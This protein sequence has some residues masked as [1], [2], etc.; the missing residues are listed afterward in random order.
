[1]F[2]AA[3][4]LLTN[5]PGW[6]ACARSIRL[7]SINQARLFATRNA[8]L[9]TP[10]TERDLYNGYLSKAFP[11]RTAARGIVLLS[12]LLTI[13]FGLAQAVPKET[14]R[15]VTKT[16]LVAIFSE[17]ET[18]WLQA[19]QQKDETTLSRL[20]SEDFQ[21]WTPQPPGAPIPREDWQKQALAHQLASFRLRQMAVRSLSNQ[22]SVAS[23][24]LSDI[25]EQGGKPQSRDHFVVDIWKK[26]GENWQCTDRYV[27]P[28][29]GN[30]RRVRAG[31]D[32][33]PSGKE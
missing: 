21:V 17:L 20:V 30:A 1:M 15:I 10:T 19:V 7:A 8:S 14:A 4:L 5:L 18:Q 3:F 16:R 24:V 11:M 6:R 13:Q 25:I 23:F 2:R 9:I 31:V 28:I 12:S 27:W 29:S 33:K 32:L 26:D 22:I